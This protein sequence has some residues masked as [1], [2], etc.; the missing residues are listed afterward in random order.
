MEVLKIQRTLRRT[1]LTTVRKI[2][3]GCVLTDDRKGLSR[4]RQQVKKERKYVICQVLY[5]CSLVFTYI[6]PIPE[7]ISQIIKRSKFR[8][9]F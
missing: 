9:L 2:V 8:Q 6:H 4:W 5:I 7:K 1:R 3:S